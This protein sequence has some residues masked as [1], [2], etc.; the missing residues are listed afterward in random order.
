MLKALVLPHLPP[1]KRR[2]TLKSFRGSRAHDF[3]WLKKQLM[4]IRSIAIP[5]SIAARLSLVNTWNTELRYKA[6]TIPNDEAE[7]FM[8]AVEHIIEWADGRL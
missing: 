7:L 4:Q 2:D 8:S 6:G 1:R 3:D 5:A